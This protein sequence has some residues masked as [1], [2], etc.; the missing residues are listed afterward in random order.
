[1][2]FW[3]IGG[4]IRLVLLMKR[5]RRVTTCLLAAALLAFGLPA[6]SQAKSYSSGG[7][8][9]YSSSGSHSSSHSSS[10][11]ASSGSTG[12]TTKSF[13]SH[14]GKSYSSGSTWSDQNRHSYTSAKSYSAGAGHSFQS[15]AGHARPT[16]AAESARR[17]Q[18][19][20]SGSTFTFDDAAARAQKEEASKAALTRFRETQA[21]PPAASGDAAPSAAGASSYRVTPPPVPARERAVYREKIYVPDAGTLASRPARAQIVFS[22]YSWRPVVVYRDP[23]NSF[24]WWWLLDRSLE[25]RAWWTYHHRYDMDPV[26]YQALVA[27]DQQLEARVEQ[28][29]AQQA[30][31]DTNYVPAGMDKDL[32]YSDRFVAQA[33][34]N[35]P[36][37]TGVL[38]FWVL[39][40]PTAAAVCVFFIWLIWFK[41]WQTST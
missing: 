23:Y 4:T 14:S 34:S 3:G 36:T 18:P 40:V 15:S 7:G 35:R 10:H 25:E 37:T 38:A 11:S 32:M 16:P 17:T 8:R 1:M 33:Y 6:G 12:S 41:R 24:F 29:E 31:R 39:G 28:L 27:N 19:D 13:S 2:G 30:P 26:R 5:P 9:S 21:A 20:A 22:P